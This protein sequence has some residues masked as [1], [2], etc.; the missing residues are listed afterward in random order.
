MISESWGE[1]IQLTGCI[2]VLLGIV[3]EFIFYANIGFVLIS[4][5]SL[6]FAIGTK[7][8]HRRRANNAKR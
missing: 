4:V 6:V 7:L 8:K 1:I 2:S 3:V 5:G